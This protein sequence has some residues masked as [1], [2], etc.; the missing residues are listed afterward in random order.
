MYY[1]FL[2]ISEDGVEVARQAHI[3]RLAD[4]SSS[5][6]PAMQEKLSLLNYLFI[7]VC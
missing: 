6:A 3:R 1:F 7:K 2:A 5:P 4:F